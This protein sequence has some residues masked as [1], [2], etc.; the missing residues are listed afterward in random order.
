M[1]LPAMYRPRAAAERAPCRGHRALVAFGIVLLGGCLFDVNV[2]TVEQTDEADQGSEEES[3]APKHESCEHRAPRPMP[4]P[5]PV[6][7]DASGRPTFDLWRAECEPLE[8]TILCAPFESFSCGHCLDQGEQANGFACLVGGPPVNCQPDEVAVGFGNGQCHACIT[9]AQKVLACCNGL[10]EFDCR[11]WPYDQDPSGPGDLCARHSD[12]ESGL[13][14][15]GGR[16][17]YGVC[18]C[19][20]REV[21]ADNRA[22]CNG[23]IL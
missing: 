15:K 22:E 5:P 17:G 11:A 10:T 9:T 20:E 21:A 14:C 1:T 12:C 13:V 2:N 16:D 18:L 23:V 8:E 7:S 4:A 19:P 3:I 6:T